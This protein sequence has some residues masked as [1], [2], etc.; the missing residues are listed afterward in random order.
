MTD[1]TADTTAPMQE[2]AT[3]FKAEEST[4]APVKH[5]DEIQITIKHGK[6][7]HTLEVRPCQTIAEMKDM[8]MKITNVP[9]AMQKLMFKGA[10]VCSVVVFHLSAYL[11]RMF[12]SLYSQ[13][14]NL[15]T[16]RKSQTPSSRLKVK[17]C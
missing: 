12:L 14:A 7:T 16:L 8:L 6:N 11:P 17:L 15:T 4:A 13:K 5:G 9:P 10:A 2:E 1:T 3:I